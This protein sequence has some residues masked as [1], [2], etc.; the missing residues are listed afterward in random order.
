MTFC[1]GKSSVGTARKRRVD[2]ISI[3]N[4]FNLF[5]LRSRLSRSLSLESLIESGFLPKNSI[6][7]NKINRV[8]IR[9]SHSATCPAVNLTWPL[10]L[11]HSIFHL[12]LWMYE[13]LEDASQSTG[14]D[15]KLTMNIH[16]EKSYSAHRLHNESKWIQRVRSDKSEWSGREKVSLVKC[17]NINEKMDSETEHHKIPITEK[18]SEF[19][20]LSTFP[21]LPLLQLYQLVIGKVSSFFFA[22]LQSS[23]PTVGCVS[24]FEFSIPPSQH[25]WQQQWP[26]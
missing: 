11:R 16:R 26:W 12:F 20:S 17:Q 22:E 9:N 23:T 15:A 2:G 5:Y 21:P 18:F 6:D 14:T 25:Q 1:D 8:V 7:N 24:R 4:S 10:C 19:F 13:K 3:R